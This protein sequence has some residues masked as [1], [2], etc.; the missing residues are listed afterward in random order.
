[1][2][3]TSFAE[4]IF[5]NAKIIGHTCRVVNIDI[6][7][8]EIEILVNFDYPRYSPATGEY[9]YS[10]LNMGT[11]GIKLNLPIST[12]YLLAKDSEIPKFYISPGGLNL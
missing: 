1:M 5:N 10:E 12:L 4:V 3:D 2:N 7:N 9:D 6:E 8:I 11:R